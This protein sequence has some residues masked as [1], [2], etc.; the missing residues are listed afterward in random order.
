MPPGRLPDCS[1]RSVSGSSSALLADTVLTHGGEATGVIPHALVERETAGRRPARGGLNARAR[2]PHGVRR[3]V[4]L[5]GGV[6]TLEELFEVYT[7]AQLGLHR[8]P[9]ALVNVAGFHD[10]VAAFLDHAVDERFNGRST[11][12]C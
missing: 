1:R 5:P 7:W 3:V 6:G 4:A 11:G 12:R 9:C 2:G 8:R 10:G